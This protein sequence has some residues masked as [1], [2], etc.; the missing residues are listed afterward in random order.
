MC[1]ICMKYRLTI[2]IKYYQPGS[3]IIIVY[4]KHCDLQFGKTDRSYSIGIQDSFKSL[5]SFAG[6]FNII[7]TY[8]YIFFYGFCKCKFILELFFIHCHFI[9][10]KD[11]INKIIF[12]KAK[13]N[14]ACFVL[15]GLF[16]E[17]VS[18]PFAKLFYKGRHQFFHRPVPQDN[19]PKTAVSCR[20]ICTINVNHFM[21][22]ENDIGMTDYNA[23][24]HINPYK[25][26][27]KFKSDSM[28]FWKL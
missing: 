15:M 12:F 14:C 22:E 3:N 23:C 21:G 18:Q 16:D 1:M 10:R 27:Y 11:L 7:I 26:I 9:I 8:N 20:D 19:K 4:C 24:K 25:Y 5:I 13:Y 17:V 2:L 28:Y 6:V